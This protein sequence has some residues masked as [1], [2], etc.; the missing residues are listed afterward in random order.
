MVRICVLTELLLPLL[1][2]L[3]LDELDDVS[4]LAWRR[5]PLPLLDDMCDDGSS[6]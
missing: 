3:R 2:S 1:C 5:L 4:F 6:C